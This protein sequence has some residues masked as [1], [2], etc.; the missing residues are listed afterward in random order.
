MA[1]K[2]QACTV[3]TNISLN[4]LYITLSGNVSGKDLDN[5]YT[6]VRFGVADLA[7]GFDVINDLT[8]CSF[9]KLNGVKTFTKMANFFIANKVKT[10]VRVVQKKQIV[11]KQIANY[12]LRKHGYKVIYVQTL[13]EAEKE[14]ESTQDR[15]S[16]R[17]HLLHHPVEYAAESAS[18]SGAL[19]DIS[20]TDCAIKADSPP[21]PDEEIQ[22][23]V[24]FPEDEKLI[25]QFT[26][27]G[28]VVWIKN[29]TFTIEYTDIDEQLQQDLWERLTKECNKDLDH[30]L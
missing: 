14:L 1:G 18:G 30:A 16:L 7:P 22:L 25:N 12:E 27:A 6:D 11:T 5:L 17:F 29:S 10:I 28:K 19:L 21:Q 13:E 26:C 8:A 3:K 15:S 20:I 9:A 24:N 2:K 4:R 23:T